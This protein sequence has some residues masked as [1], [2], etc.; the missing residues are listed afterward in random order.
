MVSRIL[1]L[2]RFW[3]YTGNPAAF[4]CGFRHFSSTAAA[5]PDLRRTSDRKAT[6][7]SPSN[8]RPV[9]ASWEVADFGRHTPSLVSLMERPIFSYESPDDTRRSL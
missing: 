9:Q 2:A 6:G 7:F 3:N 5:A 4:H 8:H 1:T